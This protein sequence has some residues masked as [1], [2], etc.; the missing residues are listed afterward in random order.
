MLLYD[1][2]EDMFREST[3]LHNR[4]TLNGYEQEGGD[5]LD[6]EDGG[7]LSLGLGVH[8]VDQELPLIFLT[9]FLQDGRHHAAGAAPVSIKINDDR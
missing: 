5:A 4:I 7:K 3:R 6:P 2:P 9:Q 1:L 8:L